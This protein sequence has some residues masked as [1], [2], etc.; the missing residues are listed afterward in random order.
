ME[1]NG[2]LIT[3]DSRR[4]DQ[5]YPI[6][7]AMYY[8]CYRYLANYYNDEM[9]AAIA[10]K[11]ETFDNY[12]RIILSGSLIFVLENPLIGKELH[13]NK[14]PSTDYSKL[15]ALSGL[16]RIRRN[17]VT[18]SIFGGDDKPLIISSGRSCNPDFFTLRKGSAI[19]EY[20][21]LS[22]SFF[23]TG[24][25]RSDGV[26]KEGNKYTLAEKKEAYYYLPMPE[27]K[28]NKNGDYKL[29][30]SLDGRFWSKMDFESRPKKTLTLETM[31]L[32][33]ETNGTFKMDFDLKG[34]E[35]TEVTLELCFR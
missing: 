28:R 31:I 1:T 6:P 32:I 35:N 25:F 21:R 19:L 30:Q 24:F 23:N 13:T 5:N 9:L 33:E 15:F 12:K 8:L 34:A 14:K 22:T 26:K 7:I 4:Q 17:E 11:I 16:A 20:A 27:N 18:A 10:K 29:S 2:D 3:L